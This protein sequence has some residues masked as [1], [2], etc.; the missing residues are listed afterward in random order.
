MN[1]ATIGT[2]LAAVIFAGSIAIIANA[3]SRR[4]PEQD[5][6]DPSV[7]VFGPSHLL[8]KH[9]VDV[10]VTNQASR[11][12]RRRLPHLNYY[13]GPILKNIKVVKVEYGAGTYQSFITGTG[14]ASIAGF[15][16]GVTNSAYFA[17]LT[18]YNTSSPA[19]TIGYGSYGG[20][21]P[22]TP[23][24]GN[25]G[26]TITDAQIQAEISAQIT[27]GHLP[28]PDANTFYAV[29]F[30]KGKSI[31]SGGSNSCV[32]GGFCAYH[33]TFSR[34]GQYVYYGVLPDMSAGSGCD[35]GCGANASPF[36]NQTSVLSHETIET[37]TD[38]GVG[39]ATVY[40]PPLAWYDPVNGEIGDICNAQ[41]GTV[42]GSNGVTYTVQKEWSNA[43]G[44]CKVH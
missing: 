6:K 23:S 26:S 44:I 1:K 24:S 11:A 28:A 4:P 13:G 20:D 14:T 22:I 31:S 43:S 29:F 27:S 19:Q 15:L 30:P 8:H 42:V 33:G 39:L 7:L 25:N 9:G 34:N 5:P 40:G 16:T 12:Y 2:G 35:L 36:N 38:A 41:Q 17:W 32:A 3:Q 21:S 18:E 10:D 37:V